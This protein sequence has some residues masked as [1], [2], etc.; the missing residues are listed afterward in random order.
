MA[1]ITAKLTT[2]MAVSLSNEQHEWQADEP[3]DARG[4]NSGP[5]PYELLLG[6][7]AVCTCV[8][9]SWYC[10]FKKLPLEFASATFGPGGES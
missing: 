8:T 7:L 6:S 5:N 9:I 4:T 3:I 1:R 10:Q 2:G